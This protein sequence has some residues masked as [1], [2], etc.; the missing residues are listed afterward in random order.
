MGRELLAETLTMMR[1]TR[2]KYVH[3]GHYVAEVEV[4]MIDDE[5][6]WSPYLSVDEACRLD[7]LRDASAGEI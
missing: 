3:E 6:S 2:T 1:R 7:D 4:E 5:S